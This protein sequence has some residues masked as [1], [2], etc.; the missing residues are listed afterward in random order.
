MKR[1]F[2]S[3]IGILVLSASAIT[4]NK[5]LNEQSKI[6][7]LLRGSIIALTQNEDLSGNES[8]GGYPICTVTYNCSSLGTVT[9]SISCTGHKCDRGTN[10]LGT[11]YVECDGVKTFC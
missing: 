5:A 2:L 4:T 1:F 10:F 3:A 6:N 8:G 11:P 9:G 7:I